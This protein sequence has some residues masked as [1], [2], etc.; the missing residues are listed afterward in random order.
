M[1]RN[2]YILEPAALQKFRPCVQGRWILLSLP[3]AEHR[4]DFGIG[5][6]EPELSP[7]SFTST[8]GRRSN[9]KAIGLMTNGRIPGSRSVSEIPW[10]DLN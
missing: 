7:W 5:T 2:I 8:T 4:A 6:F 1:S 10:L 9:K 3:E